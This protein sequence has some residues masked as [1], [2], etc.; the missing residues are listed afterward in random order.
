MN[1]LSF[2]DKKYLHDLEADLIR[3]QLQLYIFHYLIENHLNIFFSL[4][5]VCHKRFKELIYWLASKTQK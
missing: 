1:S 5:S 2:V 4:E 3:V